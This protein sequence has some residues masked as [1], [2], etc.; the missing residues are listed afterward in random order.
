[1]QRAG[2]GRPGETL[3]ERD[4]QTDRDSKGQRLRDGRIEA[5]GWRGGQTQGR[6]ETGR[7]EIGEQR[8]REGRIETRGQ[9]WGRLRDGRIELGG[10]ILREGKIETR[11]TQ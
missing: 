7:I 1:M 10:Q 9:G 5:A 11:Q 4:T 3:G 6:R 8:L 2:P